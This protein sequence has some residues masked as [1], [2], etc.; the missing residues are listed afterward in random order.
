MD[1]SVC[2]ARDDEIGIT[3]LAQYIIRSPFSTGKINYN[4]N[5]GMVTYRSR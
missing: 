5:T 1:N 4:E 2:I 3:N